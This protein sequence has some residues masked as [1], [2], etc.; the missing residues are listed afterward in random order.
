MKREQFDKTE[1]RQV[2]IFIHYAKNK[3][4]LTGVP[5][6]AHWWIYIWVLYK[7]R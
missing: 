1:E 4:N 7:S 2:T 6:R 5:E 3:K